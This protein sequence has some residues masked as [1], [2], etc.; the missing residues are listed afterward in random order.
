M[1]RRRSHPRGRSGR[2]HT[3]LRATRRSRHGWTRR[4]SHHPQPRR[5]SNPR[6]AWGTGN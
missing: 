1:G 5:R 6:P 4:S 2:W 3:G